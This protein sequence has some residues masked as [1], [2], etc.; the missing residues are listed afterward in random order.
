MY[1]PW[2]LSIILFVRQSFALV[3][4]VQVPLQDILS[5]EV[6]LPTVDESGHSTFTRMP[7]LS[8]CSLQLFDLKKAD[9][10]TIFDGFYGFD[11]NIFLTICSDEGKRIPWQRNDRFGPS[12]L[13][14]VAE[15]C[16]SDTINGEGNGFLM[17]FEKDSADVPF[18]KLF[19]VSA[20]MFCILFFFMFAYK[21]NREQKP[22]GHE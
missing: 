1:L 8:R 21:R 19:F 15:Q 9:F 2:F 20:G 22:I 12:Y 5:T 3:A 10:N 7:A 11:A 6:P 17:D 18:W 4:A 16:C 14:R 13:D